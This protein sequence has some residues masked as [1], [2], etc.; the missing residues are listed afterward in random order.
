[1]EIKVLQPIENKLSLLVTIAIL[2]VVAVCVVGGGYRYAKF[3]MPSLV[4]GATEIPSFMVERSYGVMT[5]AD[6]A[7][8]RKGPCSHDPIHISPLTDGS[9]VLTCGLPVQPG[10]VRLFVASSVQLPSIE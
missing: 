8:L 1:M 6:I 2:S 9:A 7:A 5:Q 10:P 4:S 3:H